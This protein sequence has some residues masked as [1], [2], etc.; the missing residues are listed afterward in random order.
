[1]HRRA[2]R[3]RER[4]E[5]GPGLIIRPRRDL[6]PYM[7]LLCEALLPWAEAIVGSR[8]GGDAVEYAGIALYRALQK[9]DRRRCDRLRPYLIQQVYFEA[10]D[11][12]RAAGGRWS[13]SERVRHIANTVDLV[14]RDDATADD[15]AVARVDGAEDLVAL[16]RRANRMAEPIRLLAMGLVLGDGRLGVAD[17]ARMA[18]IDRSTAW[19]R[20]ALVR[21]S[22]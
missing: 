12:L 15:V 10:R 7:P 9:F 4:F 17:I 21:G 8:F 14:E 20:F 19:K 5:A 6:T 11:E 18:N 1:M 3:V 16:A 2:K 13:R 22:L